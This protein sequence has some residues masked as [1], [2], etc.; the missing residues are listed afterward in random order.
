[1]QVIVTGSGVL[2]PNTEDS[3]GSVLI[4]H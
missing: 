3:A 4:P 2:P 1:M